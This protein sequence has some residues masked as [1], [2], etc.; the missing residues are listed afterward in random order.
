MGQL[1]MT[2]AG[3]IIGGLLGGPL[4]A[5][6]GMSLGGMIGATLF[7][8]TIKG[9]RLS[10]LKVTASTY[11]N[12]IP[13]IYGTVRVGGNMIWSDG[14]EEVKKKTGGKGAPKQEIYY[15]Y[16]TFAM[17]ICEGPIDDILRIWADGKLIFDVS[18]GASR[19]GF[20]TGPTENFGDLVGRIA[21]LGK[22]GKYGKYK[23][24][25]YPGDEEQL[26]DSL[27]EAKLGVGN[28]S[29]HRGMAYIVF[30][31]M[32]LEDFGNRI[33]Q[34]TFE[35]VKSARSYVPYITAQRLSDGGGIKGYPLT[36]TDA[37]L[38]RTFVIGGDVRIMD[39]VTLREIRY[40]PKNIYQFTSRKTYI[41]GSGL[42]V[43]E[44]GSA[45]SRQLEVWNL[46]T[47]SKVETIGISSLSTSGSFNAVTK[48]NALSAVGPICYQYGRG[49]SGRE[50]RLI[51][52]GYFRDVW[53]RTLGKDIPLFT[54]K[55]DFVPAR[56]LP[57]YEGPDG[58]ETLGWR[59]AN[60]RLET[61]RWFIGTGAEGEVVDGKWKQT[62]NWKRETAYFTPY[63]GER[64][65]AKNVAYDAADDTYF[66][67]GT[68]NGTTCAFRYSFATNEY[69]WIKKY[70]GV[71]LSASTNM[72][73][74]SV[75]GGTYGWLYWVYASGVQSK[76]YEI[77]ISSG[78]LVRQDDIAKSTFG[79]LY[80]MASLQIWD[81]ASAS[82]LVYIKDGLTRIMFRTGNSSA[83]L[84]ETLRDI[85]LD[86][87]ILTEDDLD[88]SG[89]VD[90]DFT[91]YLVDQQS[92]ARDLLK[93]LGTAFFFEGYESDYKLKFRSRGGAVTTNIPEDWIGRGSDGVAIKENLTQE[94]EMP[95]RASV[96]YY[97]VGRDHQ[98]GTQ[99][100][101]RLMGPI[102]TMWSAKELNV[103][104]PMAWTATQGKQCAEK[105]LKMSWANR[106]NY[107]FTLP[108]R[109]LKYDPTDIITVTKT[110]G[111][112]F[113]MRLG[114]V[115]IGADFTVA[116]QGISERSAAYVSTA[117]AIPGVAPEQGLYPIFPASPLILNTPLLRDMD[118][119]SSNNAVLYVA[120][121]SYGSPFAGA[122]IVIDDGPVEYST[123]GYVKSKAVTGFVTNK[124]PTTRSYE[125][126]DNTTVL[127][128]YLTDPDAT[129]ESTTTDD[130]LTLYTN[131]ALVGDEIIQFKNA[132]L[133][134]DGS[135][136]ISGILRAR[137]GT[138]YAVNSHI[139]NERF[140]LLSE[141]M[142]AKYYRSPEQYNSTR[143]FKA[144]PPGTLAGDAVAYPQ[145]LTPRDQMPY[146]PSDVQI[147]DDGTTVTI[148]A[149]RR[150]RVNA[151]LSD[152]IGDIH[153]KEGNKI[154]SRLVYRV[155]TNLGVGDTATQV[156]PTLSGQVMMFDST[157]EDVTP[158]I[159][160]PLVSLG[161]ATKILVKLYEK[162]VVDGIPKWVEFTR[163]SQ[164]DWNRVEAY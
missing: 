91:G 7:G 112:V 66:V 59:N 157:G 36:I 115:T 46:M 155:W 101:K 90:E 53:V 17:S 44:I 110:D 125:S 121:D 6:I 80:N 27:M 108:W 143:I 153:Y 136:S 88:F 104:L 138:N 47:M 134:E 37:S 123:V 126:T 160:F 116:T 83:T 22:V 72:Q 68:S 13:K 156:D 5:S 109:Y 87:N 9:P 102:P 70:P 30:D 119:D 163:A 152:G 162:G 120:A 75:T 52:I 67:I 10:D 99:Q 73:G 24:R 50:V 33:P 97:D 130:M 34:L 86:T 57:G 32:A 159:T 65:Y 154:D 98:Q 117:S 23:F 146:T 141:T 61:E 2:V 96:S 29:A 93:Q 128:V 20:P 18:A 19:L 8:P 45:N 139:N 82:A 51:M 148:T 21:M 158:T 81:G 145:T 42:Y 48:A 60:D 55:A 25:L 147:T 131:A 15:Y 151:G 149:Q 132:V 84:Q 26:P 76:L 3:G 63:A 92:T 137:R 40:V 133:N 38:G 49:S 135:W 28:V 14:I 129:L 1:I 85:C 140:V 16:S 77:N 95:M 127:T 164:G 113:T 35:V 114:E 150:S 31:R 105:M 4:G 56:M 74:N 11:G 124:L 69:L 43:R 106:F 64:F 71:G 118:Y 142:M 41:Q 12:A 144:V 58:S 122:S 161:G 39:A 107:A 111:T 89:L 78:E 54:T 103:E 94:L 62:T 79:G 100:A